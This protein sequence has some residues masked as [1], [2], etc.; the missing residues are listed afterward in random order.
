[1]R[2]AAHDAKRRRR[3][4]GRGGR[5]ARGG[6]ARRS[7]GGGRRGGGAAG[8]AGAQRAAPG[9]GADAMAGSG[10]VRCGGQAGGHASAN[11]PMGCAPG[12][13]HGGARRI[14]RRRAAIC[15]YR[16]HACERACVR[17]RAHPPA[18][19]A[20]AAW[21]A[22]R[23]AP[24]AAPRCPAAAAGRSPRARAQPP[25]RCP[26]CRCRCP[27]AAARGP[28][29]GAGGGARA[30]NEGDEHLWGGTKAGGIAVR[31]CCACLPVGGGDRVGGDADLQRRSLRR[32][33]GCA[34]R[35]G[36]ARRVKKASRGCRSSRRQKTRRT[37]T[38]AARAKHALRYLDSSR[39]GSPS[40]YVSGAILS[41][42][43]RAAR[44]F[45]PQSRVLPTE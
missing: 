28:A 22:A 8:S 10:R 13:A 31:R 40:R 44:V 24:A 7:R 35:R 42:P 34:A 45:S 14:A 12:G 15:A 23:Q 1:V 11:E 21:R 29:R 5:G 37:P 19:A 2:G 17:V 41:E 9:A 18:P 32:A 38:P 43:V 30:R 25:G 6:R 33:V 39:S 20:G 27:T 4:R 26:P 16:R 3:A 36:G